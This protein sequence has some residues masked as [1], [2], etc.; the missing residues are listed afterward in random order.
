MMQYNIVQVPDAAQLEQ[1][2]QTHYPRSVIY[3]MRPEAVENAPVPALAIPTVVCSLPSQTL[4]TENLNIHA[5]LPKPVTSKHLTKEIERLEN[6]QEILIIDDDRGFLLLLERILLSVNP[7]FKIRRA[8]SG[9]DGLNVMHTFRPDLVLMDIVI[10][11]LSGLDVLREMKVDP[12]LSEVPVILISATDD[13]LQSK[14]KQHG[15]LRVQRA[16]GLKLSELL[17]CIQAINGVLGG[18]HF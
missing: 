12:M 4:L 2:I 16:G 10:P 9:Y 8:F 1:A 14:A 3:N 18:Q 5:W 13:P 7:A 11:E 17:D 15:Q 6:V